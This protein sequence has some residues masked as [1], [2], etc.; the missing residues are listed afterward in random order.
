MCY[1][2]LLQIEYE[3]TNLHMTHPFADGDKINR[4]LTNETAI[5]VQELINHLSFIFIDS[6]HV[7]GDIIWQV[8]RR[9]LTT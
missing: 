7:R 8:K 3:N 2:V 5:T 6:H 4:T 1:V 9:T